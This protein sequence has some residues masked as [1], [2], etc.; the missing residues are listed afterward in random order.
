MINKDQYYCMWNY[1]QYFVITYKGK[2]PKTIHILYN[3]YKNNHFVIYLKQKEI[4]K[5]K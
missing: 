1:T 4:V 5:D 3:I 2:Q